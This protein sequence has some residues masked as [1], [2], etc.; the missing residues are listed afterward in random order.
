MRKAPSFDSLFEAADALVVTLRA[1]AAACVAFIDDFAR[2]GA[3]SDDE[4]FLAQR[5]RFQAFATARLEFDGL[6]GEMVAGLDRMTAEVSADLDSFRGLTAREKLTGWFSRQRMWHLHSQRVRA[7]P[8]I[9]RL[10]DLLS[11]SNTLAG[12]VASH[13]EFALACHNAAERSVITIVGQRRRLVDAIEISRLR[14]KELNAKALTRQGRI[15]LYGGKAE[16]ERM[17]EERRTLKQ[18]A[19]KIAEEEQSMRH[20]T[21]RR[22]RFIT[23]FE[24]LVEGL[25]SQIGLCNAL[26]RKLSIDTE[27]R[28]II[29]QAQVDGEAPGS[30]GKITQELFPHIA[31]PI[32]LFE[33][34]M[35]VPQ[36]IGPRK[37]AADA[38]F[39][40]KF[41][42]FAESGDAAD[43]PIIDL[44]QKPSGFRLPF[45]RS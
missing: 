36:E 13:R 7:A 18:Q 35:L 39:A 33:K 41:A 2:N 27:E 34:D 3:Q 30:K 6:L 37:A 9:E 15:G 24:A 8:V 38:V 43:A 5:H 11:K 14:T 10:L 20:E 12:L 40:R 32:S 23:M 21:Q 42:A 29:Y 44:T 22:E 4:A 17:E 31:G 16:W 26:A 25:N 45:L 28:L 19:D 1:E